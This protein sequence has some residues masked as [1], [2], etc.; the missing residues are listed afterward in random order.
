ML[1]AVK[2]F[3]ILVN[4]VVFDPHLITVMYKIYDWLISTVSS[5]SCRP[6]PYTISSL[7]WYSQETDILGVIKQGV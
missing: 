6:R 5:E 3:N 1:F 7:M 4:K 2:Y